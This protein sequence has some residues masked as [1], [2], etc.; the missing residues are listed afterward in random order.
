M[1]DEI[2]AGVSPDFAGSEKQDVLDPIFSTLR[3]MYC[4]DAKDVAPVLISVSFLIF[5]SPGSPH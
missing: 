3:M 4:T 5:C 1:F 2:L